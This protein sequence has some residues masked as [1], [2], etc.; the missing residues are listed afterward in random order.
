MEIQ[1]LSTYLKNEHLVRII[2]CTRGSTPKQFCKFLTSYQEID[3]FYFVA[4]ICIYIYEV[5]VEPL[6]QWMVKDY[7]D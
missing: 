1:N 3:K 6:V 2:H 7:S 4:T 5:S